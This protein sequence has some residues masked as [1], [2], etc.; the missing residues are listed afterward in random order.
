MEGN[1]GNLIQPGRRNEAASNFLLRWTSLYIILAVATRP[2][3]SE[4]PSLQSLSTVSPPVANCWP[5]GLIL[6]RVVCSTIKVDFI[7]CQVIFTGNYNFEY[8]GNFHICRLPCCPK[9]LPCMRRAIASV[10]PALVNL[11]HQHPPNKTKSAHSPECTTLVSG[12][13]SSGHYEAQPCLYVWYPAGPRYSGL[14]RG[15]TWLET[16]EY[17]PTAI[18][19]ATW[20]PVEPARAGL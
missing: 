5:V 19:G 16:C 9:P 1:D 20:P 15:F 18:G 4:P 8:T 7:C 11:T 6:P 3:H 17:V 2:A 14:L 12:T 13:C 10:V